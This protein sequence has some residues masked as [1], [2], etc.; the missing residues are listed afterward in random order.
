[1][2]LDKY[3]KPTQLKYVKMLV[4]DDLQGD[5]MMDKVKANISK[6]AVVKTDDFRSYSRINQLVWRHQPLKVPKE[7]LDKAFPWVHIVILKI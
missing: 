1:M 2:N 4:I 7:K 6:Q 5:T 3:A